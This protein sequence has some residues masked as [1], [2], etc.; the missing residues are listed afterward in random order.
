MSILAT[1]IVESSESDNIARKTVEVLAPSAPNL[2]VQPRNVG[3]NPAAPTEGDR[4]LIRA[5]VLN[6][7]AEDAADVVVQI[8]DVT[9]AGAVPIGRPHVITFLAA[10]SSAT[11]PIVYDTLDK[12]GVRRIRV[13]VDPSNFIRESNK[14]DNQAVVSLPVRA[15]MAPNLA[16]LSGNIKFDPQSPQIHDLV[17]VSATVLN[18]GLR[19]RP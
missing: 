11:V 12:P 14:E 9:E 15:A 16:M 1:L 19:H 7:G 13:V 3:F 10:G 8:L 17:T 18:N 6:D 4:V 5:I 2:I